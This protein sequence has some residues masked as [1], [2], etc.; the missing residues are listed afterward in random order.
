MALGVTVTFDLAG[1]EVSLT[2]DIPPLLPTM[3]AADAELPVNQ[4]EARLLEIIKK[5]G[6][7]EPT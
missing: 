7:P 1:A 6:L 2:P 5:V 4:A 3:K